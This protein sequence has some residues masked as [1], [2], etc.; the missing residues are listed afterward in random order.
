VKHLGQ[1]TVGLIEQEVK[2]HFPE[3]AVRDEG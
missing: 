2:G 3:G 1:A